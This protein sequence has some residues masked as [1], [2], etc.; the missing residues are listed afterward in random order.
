MAEETIGFIGLGDMGEPMAARLLGHG[1]AVA[2][3]AH[4][5]R[6]AIEALKR[7]GLVERAV[8]ADCDILMTIVMDQEQTDR[9]LRGP[10]GALATMRPGATLIIMST[11]SPA[12]CQALAEELR[13]KS[14][15]VI[16]CP[17]TGARPRAENGTLGLIVGGEPAAVERCRA[18]LETMGSVHY[19]GDIGMG[20]VVKLANNAIA[21]ATGSLV[22][23]A[24]A[25]A[26]AYGVDMN[27]LMGVCRSGTANSFIVQTWDWVAANLPKLMPLGVKDAQICRDAATAKA[28]PMPMLDSYLAQ[29]WSR[30]NSAAKEL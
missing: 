11:I 12:Y 7:K 10:D 1:Y 28:I 6:E 24:R 17:V 15:E 4:R 20:M 2:S 3:C 22:L 9:V 18:A 26:R 29:D 27:V 23:E 25:F 21:F 30:L 5:R 19:C 16:D 14:I 13:R 8:A